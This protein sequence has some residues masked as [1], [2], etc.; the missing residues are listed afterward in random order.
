MEGEPATG[1]DPR[2]SE[3]LLKASAKGLEQLVG[4]LLQRRANADSAR[5][6]GWTALMA[7]SSAGH[8]AVT[9]LLLAHGANVQAVAIADGFTALL[10]ACASGRRDIADA[11]IQ[12][13]AD[14]S[15]AS[16]T[17]TTPL[18]VASLH[19]HAEVV[20]LL[21]QHGAD[22]MYARPDGLTAL[23][24]AC[25]NGHTN[26]AVCLIDHGVS[27]AGSEG[28][29][30][31]MSACA[32]GHA[33]V[34]ELLLEGGVAATAAAADGT[35]ALM[36]ACMAGHREVGAV[37]AS[38]GADVEGA[39]DIAR[40]QSL[41]GVSRVLKRVRPAARQ[42]PEETRDLDDLV[43]GIEGAS[44]VPRA[45]ASA[46]A[47]KVRS[48]G[49]ATN[50]CPSG[51]ATVGENGATSADV[52]VA[53]RQSAASARPALEEYPPL[54]EEM[55]SDGADATLNARAVNQD[56]AVIADAVS[57][58]A[59]AACGEERRQPPAHAAA[60]PADLEEKAVDA[61]AAPEG[62]RAAPPAQL[63]G[64][65]SLPG[66]SRWQLRRLLKASPAP[67]TYY[68]VEVLAI[69]ACAARSES[70]CGTGKSR[71]RNLEVITAL[72][73]GRPV[74]ELALLPLTAADIA[75]AKHLEEGGITLA[76]VA[77]EA[78]APPLPSSTSSSPSSLPDRD[79]LEEYTAWC[80]R[81]RRQCLKAG[82][83]GLA[84]QGLA[85]AC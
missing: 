11:L 56:H 60:P 27:L 48:S 33:E 83:S 1:P 34:A 8:L 49:R 61:T 71:E 51:A 54:A 72:C 38:H 5:S 75:E 77:A 19:G 9:E 65:A 46:R 21:L 78:P 45:R 4:L 18:L 82:R 17:G 57:D 28:V 22:A 32:S 74:T 85:R 66:A 23:R 36:Q 63:A 10:E 53:D 50:V 41:S 73:E 81:A 37:L 62:A 20:L 6:D 44:A 42:A 68:T 2:L 29:A 55:A 76:T 3:Q 58:D 16:H 35:T 70:S 7:A 24:A 12:R 80:S 47:A 14:V 64:P 79:A 52:V 67:G 30:A 69:E 59:Q 40:R 39:L 31:L 84:R 43:R 26:V 25:G 13:G 15:L